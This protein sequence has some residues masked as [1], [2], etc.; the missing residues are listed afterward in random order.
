VFRIL[1]LDGGG[2]RGAFGAAYLAAL[3]EQLQTLGK[4][5]LHEYFDLIASTSTGA[6]LT[7]GVALGIPAGTLLRLYQTAGQAIFTPRDEE[8][9]SQVRLLAPARTSGQAGRQ[10]LPANRSSWA[11]RYIREVFEKELKALSWTRLLPLQETSA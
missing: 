5:K 11:T 8:D 4:G 1:S 6:I 10:V 7:L 2:I 9:F 3:E